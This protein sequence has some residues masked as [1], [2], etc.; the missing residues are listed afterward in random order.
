MELFQLQSLKL[1]CKRFSC[2]FGQCE[3]LIVNNVLNYTC[4]CIKVNK[5]ESEKVILNN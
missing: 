2:R 3:N 1:P 4:H 5:F